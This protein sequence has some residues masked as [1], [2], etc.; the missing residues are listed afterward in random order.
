ME[1]NK[2]KEYIKIMST[3]IMSLLLILFTQWIK[4]LKNP[5]STPITI[6]TLTGLIILGIFS[7]LGIF[8]HS[9]VQKFPFK[10]IKDFPILGWVSMVSLA[11][12][13]ISP[14]VIK[15][16]N[17]VDFLSITTP[18]LTYAGIS[19]AD[20]LGDLRKVSWKIV[21]VGIFVFLGTYLGSAILAE[22]GFLLSGK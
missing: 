1:N 22:I 5:K 14:Q 10:I 3:L 8:I 19:I 17:S 15:A 16:I 9:A 20:R 11:G 13:L 7:V 2:K 4:L 21:I 18:I 6:E 12:C